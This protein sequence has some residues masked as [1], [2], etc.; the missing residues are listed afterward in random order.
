[1]RY[2]RLGL[3]IVLIIAA[4]GLFY[5]SSWTNAMVVSEGEVPGILSEVR[6]FVPLFY[7]VFIVVGVGLLV[8]L[9]LESKS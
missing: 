3:L 4:T 2:K 8:N 7:G 6:T 1:M 5:F 9:I